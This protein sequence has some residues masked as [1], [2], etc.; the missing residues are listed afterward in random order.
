MRLHVLGYN[1]PF[2]ESNGATSGYLLEAA[3]TLVQFDLGSGV[4]SRLLARTPV[5]ALDALFLSHWHYDHAS[6]LLPLIY[7]LQASG[8]SLTVYAPAD[9]GAELRK[10]VGDIPL[11]RLRT[12]GPGDV[13]TVGALTVRVC[14][15]RHPVPTVGFR[16]EDGHSVFGYTGDTNT[17]PELAACYRGCDLLLADGLFP[18][19]AWSA[20]KPHLSAA[21]A[22]RLGA[23]AGVRALV[24]THLNPFFSPAVLLQEARAFH[25]D[26]QLASSRTVFDL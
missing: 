4:L 22:G 6:D 24:I 3:D 13:L 10:I 7:L 14:P 16:V 11:L 15:A 20:D 9:P 19:K 18:E 8:H 25:P 17:L 12:V 21:L 26:V 23:E 1:G 2:P 5:E